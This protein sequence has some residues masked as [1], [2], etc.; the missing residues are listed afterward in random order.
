MT[1]SRQPTHHGYAVNVKDRALY[2]DHS[3]LSDDDA[4]MIWERAAEGFWADAEL[5]ATE[6]GFQTVYGEGRMGGWCVP[7]P[8]PSGDADERELAEWMAE[9]FRP[10]ERDVL[11][12]IGYWRDEFRAE[13]A[14][15]VR[16]AQAE[17]AEAAYWAARDVMTI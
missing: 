9:R 6:H 12:A 11:E 3:P 15:A 8:Q 10:F 4:Q 1:E 16:L 7:Q 2:G 17:P 14:E 5:L 13:L